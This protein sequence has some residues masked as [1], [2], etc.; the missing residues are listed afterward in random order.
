[1]RGL[2]TEYVRFASQS[3][4]PVRSQPYI[5]LALLLLAQT[6][7]L[8]WSAT[9]HSPCIDEVGHLA[10]GLH[11]WKT[12]T[13]DLYRVNPPLVRLV[14]TAPLA[15]AG[16]D[17]PEGGLNVTPPARPEFGLGQRLVSQH[18]QRAF[19]WVFVARWACIPF[20]CL[21][22]MMI[23]IWGAALYGRSAGTLSAVLWVACPTVLANAQMITPDTGAASLGLAACYAFWRWA[24]VPSWSTALVTGGIFGLAALSKT[25][26]VLLIPVWSIA[27]ALYRFRNSDRVERGSWYELRQLA[28]IFLIGFYLLNTGYVFEDVGEPLDEYRFVS[29][30]LTAETDT[31][32]RENRFQGTWIGHL[33]LPLPRNYVQG[34]DVQKRDFEIGMRS[35]LRGEWRTEGWWYYYLYGL[36]VKTPIGTLLLFGLAL[37]SCFG[38]TQTAP[39]WRDELF[40]LLPGVTVLAFVSSQT[41]FNHHLRYVLPAL[42]FLFVWVGRVAVYAGKGA[43]YWRA[44]VVV[45][46][47]WTLVSSLSAYPHSLSYFNEAVGGPRHGSEHLVDSNID[48]GQDLLYLKRWLDANPQAQPLGLAYFGYIDPR[49]AGIVFTLPPRGAAYPTDFLSPQSDAVGPKPGWYAVS[50]NILR[51]HYYMLPDGNGRMV[52]SEGQGY[53]YFLRFQPVASAG[54]SI[55]IYR[56]EPDECNRVRNELGLPPLPPDLRKGARAQ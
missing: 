10:A 54:Y 5:C 44:M 32:R 14:A 30:A 26:W 18:G 41:G 28:T 13:F 27:W 17:L 12:G 22:T 9:R 29:R 3:I 2:M 20:A 46:T 24:R 42:P 48:W 23:Y 55:W 47:L 7:L 43:L 45:A 35:Y 53:D 33:P 25:T 15:A 11:H 40:L 56:L 19:Q 37:V 16:V 6:A 39:R 49:S 50:V 51:G 36:L 52:P 31:E 38:S 8:G 1:M 34:I 21:G 4:A